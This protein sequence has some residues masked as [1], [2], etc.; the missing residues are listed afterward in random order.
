MVINIPVIGLV[1]IAFMLAVVLSGVI[2]K[3]AKMLGRV[4]IFL[5]IFYMLLILFGLA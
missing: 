5:A 4:I 1:L 3:A 2:I